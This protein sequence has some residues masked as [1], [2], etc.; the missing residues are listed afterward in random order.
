MQQEKLRTQPSPLRCPYC[1]EGVEVERDEWVACQ[2][3]LGRHHASCWD[4]TGTCASCQGSACLRA[5][6]ALAASDEA[7]EPA[8]PAQDLIRILEAHEQATDGPVADYLLSPLTLALYPVLANEQR[9]LDHVER[10]RAELET[11]AREGEDARVA[12]YRSEALD[13]EQD[14]RSR[15]RVASALLPVL[16]TVFVSGVVILATEAFGGSE[17]IGIPMMLLS[18][19]GWVVS[20]VT[21]LAL[22]WKAVRTHGSKQLYLGLLQRGTSEDEARRI[23]AEHERDWKKNGLIAACTTLAFCLPSPLAF[24]LPIWLAKAWKM[25]LDLHKE[26]EGRVPEL[27]PRQ[28]V[29]KDASIE[30]PPTPDSP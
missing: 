21:L 19:I 17:D 8:A 12:R 3:C 5:D 7:L 22:H 20:Q 2:S 18:V 1:H 15:R 13:V 11:S 27:F 10:N 29:H 23:L 14:S 28:V 25:P 24:G 9:L 6:E 16:L 30:D 4:E 26:R